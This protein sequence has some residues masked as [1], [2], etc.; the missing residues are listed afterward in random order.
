MSDKTLYKYENLNKDEISIKAL[1]NKESESIIIPDEIDKLPVIGISQFAFY[2]NRNLKSVVLPESIKYIGNRAFSGT[3]I[4]SITLPKGLLYIDDFAFS[5]CKDLEEII[6]P[7]DSNIEIGELAFDK[8]AYSRNPKNWENNIL[9]LG[10]YVLTAKNN[11]T[12]HIKPGTKSIADNAFENNSMTELHIPDSVIHIGNE[13]F[14]YCENLKD[15][16]IG[17]GVKTFGCAVFSSCS[18]L[19][20]VFIKKGLSEIGSQMFSF[21]TALKNIQLPDGIQKIGN[22][23]FS[24]C[25]SLESINIPNTVTDIKLS[26]FFECTN[27]VSAVLGKN[28]KTI[29]PMSFAHCPSLQHISIKSRT[30][31][32]KAP[33]IDNNEIRDKIQVTC[34]K[35]STVWN[36]LLQMKITPQKIESN[37]EK[38]LNEDKAEKYI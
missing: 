12:H 2:N 17:N 5:E 1:K 36:S 11:H 31:K 20:N 15:L 32:I 7:L 35:N 29:E 21:C 9:Y 28:I 19:Q 38:Y 25:T 33:M 30:A 37:M 8:T 27:L 26:A 6:I 18:S 13:A 24:Y 34:Y 22:S 3:G 14:S 23:A 10:E 16:Y 4:K